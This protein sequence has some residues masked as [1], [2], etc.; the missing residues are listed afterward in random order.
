[1]KKVELLKSNRNMNLSEKLYR[2]IWN[3]TWFSLARWTP[4]FFNSWRIFLLKFFGA[5]I[6]EKVLIFGSVKID[7]PSNF[8]IGDYSAI[9]KRVWVYNFSK[10]KIGSNSVVSQDTTI[11]SASHDYSH[12]YMSLY[13]KPISIGDNVWLAANCF[14]MPGITI[15][16]GAVVGACSVVT[17]D[18]SE[19]TVNAGNPCKTVRKRVLVDEIEVTNLK[20]YYL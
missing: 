13:A 1:M 16:D 4:R 14:I 3:F 17:K 6:G 15:E 2:G 12:P 7:I 8:E 19:W 5:K 20:D 11:C 18:I 9:G 10:I